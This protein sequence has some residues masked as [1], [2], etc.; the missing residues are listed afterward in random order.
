MIAHMESFDRKSLVAFFEKCAEREE[1]EEIETPELPAESLEDLP[2]SETAAPPTPVSASTR[3]RVLL[4]KS[5]LSGVAEPEP[6]KVRRRK[7]PLRTTMPEVPVEP[8][9]RLQS[10]VSRA[11]RGDREAVEAIRLELETKPAIWQAVGDLAAHS[12]SL[13]INV[14]AAGNPLVSQSLEREIERLKT[15]LLEG[16]TPSPL[17]RLAIQRIVACWLHAQYVD[18]ATL[19]A[20]ASLGVKTGD[21]ARRQE[22][23]EK[24]FLLAIKSLDLARRLKPRRTRLE[25]GGGATAPQPEEVKK[26][27]V[28]SKKER[29]G[30][31]GKE[32]VKSV[33]ESATSRHR[34][35]QPAF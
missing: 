8:L 13:L 29:R 26:S 35:P 15:D 33:R 25:E 21:W 14:I 18:R 20:D 16:N 12:E 7:D 6:A 28:S 5:P 27:A 34:E 2:S 24:R 17:E 19:I 22:V 23:A 31:E 1:F 10:L 32:A 9:A 30:A 11:T 3:P 4:R